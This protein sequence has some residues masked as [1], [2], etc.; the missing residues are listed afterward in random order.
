MCNM[1]AELCLTNYCNYNITNILYHIG[2]LLYYLFDSQYQYTGWT[3]LHIA[4]MYNNVQVA[5][6]LIDANA[7]LDSLDEVMINF[8]YIKQ[9]M[10][11]NS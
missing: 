5:R 8:F 2:F 11:M 1:Y 10:I 7:N 3:P 4:A 9:T 6:I